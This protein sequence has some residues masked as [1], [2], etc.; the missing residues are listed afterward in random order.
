MARP[1]WEAMDLDDRARLIDKRLRKQIRFQLYAYSP[2]YR[3]LLDDLGLEGAGFTGVEDLPKL[4]TVSRALLAAAPNEFVLR[5]SRS[6]MQRWGAAGQVTEAVLNVLLRG[7]ASFERELVHDYRP[8]HTLETSGTT[9]EPIP[10][11]LSRRDLAVL[12]TASR[13]MLDIAGVT[14]D[15]VVMNLLEPVRPGGFWAFW[16]GAVGLGVRQIVPGVLEPKEA[17]ALA[18]KSRATVIV[19]RALDLLD[20]LEAAGDARLPDLRTIL[21]APESMPPGLRKRVAEAVGPGVRLVETYG[22]AEGRSIWVECASGAGHPDAGFHT[23]GDLEIFEAVSIRTGEPVNYG[24]L[25]EIVFTGLD[26]RGTA[27]ARYRPGDIAVGGLMRGR[28]PYC[29]RTVDRLIGPI[30]RSTSLLSLHL[31]GSEPVAIDVDALATAIAHPA[32]AGWQIE[33]RKSEGD[34]RGADE[35]YVMYVPAPNRDA[36]QLAVDLD[37]AFRKD[38]GLSVTQFVLSEKVEDGVVDLRPVPAEPIGADGWAKSGGRIRL[39]RHPP[40]RTR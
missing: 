37:R 12:G 22:F 38:I 15:D 28:C 8:V 9:G 31:A 27:L 26:Q 36:G 11:Y 34:P 3:D 29:G 19:A 1:T 40:G 4:P 20:M 30:R 17:A 21:L 10:I 32:L 16:A 25:G 2:F 33:V 35:V 7:D 14:V 13:R 18:V 23:T 6:L 5:P 39:W 24:E